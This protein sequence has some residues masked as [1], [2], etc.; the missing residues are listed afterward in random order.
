MQAGLPRSVV[1]QRRPAVAGLHDLPD[2]AWFVH[3]PGK[4]P[5]DAI[6]GFGE[7]DVLTTRAA[8]GEVLVADPAR[9]QRHALVVGGIACQ[10]V[11]REVAKVGSH[12]EARSD[13]APVIRGVGGTVLD[14]SLDVDHPHEPGILHAA[15]LFGRNGG[16]DSL[17][18]LRFDGEA[19]VIGGCRDGAQRLDLSTAAGA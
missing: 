17:A 6:L 9:E 12:D 13:V 2:L 19:R 4:S 7:G 1:I 5:D 14:A 11:N 18:Q 3:R 15:M 16:K 8:Q 10:P